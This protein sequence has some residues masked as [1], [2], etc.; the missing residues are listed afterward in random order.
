MTSQLGTN[1]AG[2]L[3]SLLYFENQHKTAGRA[4]WEAHDQV[5][6][7]DILV[8]TVLKRSMAL[9]SGFRAMLMAQNFACAAPLVRLEL[10]TSLRLFAAGL[11][12]D[13][14]DFV[15]RL[16]EGEHIR[17]M[18]D[19]DGH[20]LTDKY[21]VDRLAEHYP[22]ATSIYG[23][24]SGDIHLSESHLRQAFRLQKDAPGTFEMA[25]TARDPFVSEATRV[26]AARDFLF[27]A[28]VLFDLVADWVLQKRTYRGFA[29]SG[30]DA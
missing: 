2:L 14:D 13:V 28:Q 21:L 23:R 22:D 26:E 4:V 7:P 8:F 16:A 12:G 24:Y 11:F 9:H 27:G 29:N 10:D 17:Q 19:S 5:Y 15:M 30:D 18:K 20:R 1:L 25:I 3:E 6:L